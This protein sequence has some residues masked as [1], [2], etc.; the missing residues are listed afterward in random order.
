MKNRVPIHLY[1]SYETPCSEVE[2][3]WLE[4]RTAKELESL[5]NN[6]PEPAVIPVIKDPSLIEECLG[7]A[8]NGI[9]VPLGF[10]DDLLRLTH[11]LIQTYTTIYLIEEEFMKTRTDDNILTSLNRVKSAVVEIK[12]TG[13]RN[14]AIDLFHPDPVV[15]FKSNQHLKKKL[16]LNHVISLV[17]MPDSTDPVENIVRNALSIS[18]LFYRQ[19]GSVLLIKPQELEQEKEALEVGRSILANLKLYDRTHRI[20]SCPGCGRCQWDIEPMTRRIKTELDKIVESYG[21][22]KQK[23]EECGGIAV[24]VMGC[25]VNGPGEASDADIGVAGGKN[26]TVTI[27]KLGKPYKTVREDEIFSEMSKGIREVIDF[28]IGKSN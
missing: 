1:R 7:N 21:A 12:K 19:I 9:A 27:F 20:I 11:L 24:A 3:L 13:V 5:K 25:N 22:E 8:R 6:R 16:N 4:V 2:A 10:K 14:L 15:H 18:S 26:R 23:L 28:K 17:P